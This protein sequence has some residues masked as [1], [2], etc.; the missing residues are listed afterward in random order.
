MRKILLMSSA[1]VANVLLSS[2]TEAACIQTPNCTTLG[3]TSTTACEGGLK[4][5]WG[6]AWFCNIGSGTGGNSGNIAACHVG[7]VLNSDKSCTEGQELG[8]V[9][10]GIIVYADGK[11]HGQAIALES[12]EIKE[13][14]NLCSELSI[15][16]Y[17]KTFSNCTTGDDGRK[18]CYYPATIS[19]FQIYPACTRR[20]SADIIYIEG[21][22]RTE[23]ANL[24]E[25]SIDFDSKA[26]TDNVLNSKDK[27]LQYIT[28]LKKEFET[29]EK[30]IQESFQGY[31]TED[32]TISSP[33]SEE[34]WKKANIV[35]R[36][37]VENFSF[38]SEDVAP[39]MINAAEKVRQYKTTGTN[40]GDWHLPAPGLFNSIKV[41]ADQ[42][43]AGYKALNR[44][45]PKFYTTGFTLKDTIE[46]Y[47]IY[48]PNLTK[49]VTATPPKYNQDK[50]SVHSSTYIS[51]LKYVVPDSRYISVKAA[52][53]SIYYSENGLYGTF[54]MP[55]N[56]YGRAPRTLTIYPVIY[57]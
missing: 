28:N 18:T 46:D 1:L 42:I 12:I 22:G 3:Y 16:D 36:K 39:Y 47:Q 56:N 19:D 32:F 13:S 37:I 4:C 49:P 25:A 51:D 55:Y 35:E 30:N 2:G 11:G 45:M 50:V 17:Y 8:K 10:I 33:D 40:A 24:E 52:D 43:K 9:P 7:A 15:A 21:T 53:T 41:Y 54:S 57:F 26:L 34:D 6:N 31:A 23:Y 14:Y 38:I 27:Y 44:S 20:E 48:V 5:P 29:S